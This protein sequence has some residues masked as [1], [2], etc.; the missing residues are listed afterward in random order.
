MTITDIFPVSYQGAGRVRVQW[1]KTLA[2]PS[3]PTL[4]EIDGATSF[5]ATC[6]FQSEAFEITHEQERVDDTRL[7]DETTRE[8][9][10]RSTFGIEELAYIYDPNDNTPNTPGNLAKGAFGTGESGYF[11]TR[12]GPASS[13]DFAAEQIVEVYS[14]QFGTQHKTVP[15][16]ENAKFTITQPLSMTRVAYDYVIPAGP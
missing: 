6:Y 13:A 9:F 2:V 5:D 11:V 4:A 15:A 3:A 8:S 7:C 10:G 16:G 14:V 12:F 1:V